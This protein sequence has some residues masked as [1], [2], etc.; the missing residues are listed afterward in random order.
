MVMVM[1][2]VIVM[3]MIM[4]IHTQVHA[5]ASR[6]DSF[7]R[8]ESNALLKSV[9]VLQYREEDFKRWLARSLER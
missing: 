9:A 6:A 1:M 8:E 4:I 3:V 2:M 7:S 5:T